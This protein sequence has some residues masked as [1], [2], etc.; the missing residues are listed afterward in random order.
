MFSKTKTMRDISTLTP[1]EGAGLWDAVMPVGHKPFIGQVYKFDANEDSPERVVFMSGCERLGVYFD[2]KVW[3]DCDL[4]PVELNQNEVRRY[5]A[6]IG[7]FIDAKSPQELGDELCDFCPL[8]K[9]GVYSVPGGFCAG[10]DGSRCTEAYE[11][12]LES[13]ID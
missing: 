11:N 10:C 12:Y 5:L 3:A 9:K 6:R 8:E 13:L 2:G 1:E 7:I 4:S